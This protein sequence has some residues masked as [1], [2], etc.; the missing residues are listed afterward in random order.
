[1][2]TYAIF[3]QRNNGEWAHITD[4]SFDDFN[5][6]YDFSVHLHLESGINMEVREI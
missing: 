2:K 6:A 4:W 1:M 3:A 5:K